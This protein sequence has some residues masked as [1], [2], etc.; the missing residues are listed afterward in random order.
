MKPNRPARILFAACLVVAIGACRRSTEP[1][2]LVGTFVASTFLITPNGQGTLNVLA[3]GGVLGINIA[4]T[5][6]SFT[7]AGTLILPPALTTQT[8]TINLMGTASRTDNLVR[9]VPS[10]PSFLTELTFTL[11][12]NTLTTNQTVADTTYDIVLTRY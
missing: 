6:G 9:F 7:T 2:P 10:V 5:S 12:V 4:T 3:Q 11:G 8:V 1:D